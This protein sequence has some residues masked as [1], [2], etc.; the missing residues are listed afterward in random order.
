MKSFLQTSQHSYA[1]QSK[2]AWK[3][4]TNL[5]TDQ[6]QA[7]SQD[8]IHWLQSSLQIFGRSWRRTCL[9][10]YK[11]YLT[12]KEAAIFCGVHRWLLPRSR[13]EWK[14]PSSYIKR[15]VNIDSWDITCAWSERRTKTICIRQKMVCFCTF[16]IHVYYLKT[17]GWLKTPLCFFLQASGG[18]PPSSGS[19]P[20]GSYSGNPPPVMMPGGYPVSLNL[21]A[22]FTFHF[23][24]LI[25]VA[26][27][28]VLQTLHLDLRVFGTLRSHYL[29]NR[30][31]FPNVYTLDSIIFQMCIM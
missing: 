18:Y 3:I 25:T 17:R 26:V 14:L 29:Y 11:K 28:V 31:R 9:A 1:S 20:G 13:A 6:L 30:L 7:Q 12:S 16:K 22:F 4:F 19:G 15:T 8:P 27:E 21:V 10:I 2:F 24:T 23:R 5:T